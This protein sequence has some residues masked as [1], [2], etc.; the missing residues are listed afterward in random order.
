MA[1]QCYFIT[2][3]IKLA[4]CYFI[5]MLTV[6]MQWSCGHHSKERKG[7]TRLGMQALLCRLCIRVPA[8]CCCFGMP[9]H[10]NIASWLSRKNGELGVCAPDPHTPPTQKKKKSLALTSKA[11]G[12]LQT[13]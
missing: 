12:K 8:Y 7:S 13:F 5:A 6:Q 1:W 4:C 11:S 3:A 10:L 9:L 2:A